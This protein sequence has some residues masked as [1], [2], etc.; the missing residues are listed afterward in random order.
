MESTGGTAGRRA[1]TLIFAA[2]QVLV[3]SLP[4]L[5]IGQDIG[6]RSDANQTLITPAGWAFSIW[7]LLYAGCFAYAIYQALPARSDDLLVRK[8]GWL[9]AGAFLGN[10]L[11]A[12]YVQLVDIG[13][14]SA[15]III[16]TLL[17]TLAAVVTFANWRPSFTTS[18]QFC[19]VAP[20]SALAGWLTAA[21]IVNI[22]SVLVFLDVEL[23][24]PVTIA[25]ATVFF[26]SL[27]VAFALLRTGGNPWYAATFLWALIGVIAAAPEEAQLLRLATIGSAAIVAG[28][29]LFGLFARRGLERYFRAE[30]GA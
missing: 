21:T 8:L 24:A 1:A 22:A 7:G 27:I 6:T 15:L 16:G 23:P 29:A 28:A 20:L 11:W 14:V 2:T 13:P 19:A 12:L 4:A 10:T 9:P 30:R 17:C 26:G 5:G 18:Q 25:A 3:P